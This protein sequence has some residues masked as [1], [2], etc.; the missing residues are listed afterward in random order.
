MLAEALKRYAKKKQILGS[1][2]DNAFQVST[3][4]DEDDE[5]L[6]IVAT[7]LCHGTQRRDCDYPNTRIH[8]KLQ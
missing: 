7:K 8:V 1:A 4:Q 2:I 6:S 3:L 5:A